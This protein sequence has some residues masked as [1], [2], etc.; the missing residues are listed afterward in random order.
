MREVLVHSGDAL[1]DAEFL[2]FVVMMSRELKSMASERT[3]LEL[4]SALRSVEAISQRLLN[5]TTP[6]G[7]KRP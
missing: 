5:T 2:G 6:R 1:S 3:M 4:S 7:M